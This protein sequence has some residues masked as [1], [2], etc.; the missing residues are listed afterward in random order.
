MNPLGKPIL[1][2]IALTHNESHSDSS[3][4]QPVSST[5]VSNCLVASTC[6][7][8]CNYLLSLVHVY[9]CVKQFLLFT[10][11]DSFSFFYDRQ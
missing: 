9:E 8:I 1:K 6:V 7:T 10:T 11:L 2:P 3:S 5:L 4:Q